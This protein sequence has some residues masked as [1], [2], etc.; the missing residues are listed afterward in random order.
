[1]LAMVQEI[2]SRT[3]DSAVQQSQ[4]PV[5]V[6]VYASWCPRCAMMADTVGTFAKENVGRIRVC[7]IE[8]KD[9]LFLVK[10]YGVD[11]VP[12]FLAFRQGKVI[13]MATGMVSKDVLK[14]MFR[15]E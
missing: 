6:E 7:R 4:M 5:L 14:D 13:G 11:R 15:G 1:M 2:S 10:R 12:A 3:F 9:A 8:E